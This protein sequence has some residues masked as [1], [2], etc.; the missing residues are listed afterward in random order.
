VTSSV[1]F[2]SIIVGAAVLF[3]I[4][5]LKATSSVSFISI[6]VG[7]VVLFGIVGLIWHF[8]SKN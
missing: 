7:A 6:I 2:I 5:G 4:V 1:S 8:A 3:G